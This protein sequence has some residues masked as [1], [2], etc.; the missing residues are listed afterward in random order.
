MTSGRRGRKLGDVR[1]QPG[2][3]P[4]APRRLTQRLIQVSLLR[5][6]WREVR[7]EV[8]VSR[9]P[10]S[11]ST[12]S[13]AH[14]QAWLRMLLAQHLLR[15]TCVIQQPLQGGPGSACHEGETSSVKCRVYTEER[16]WE[17]EGAA[18]PPALALWTGAGSGSMPTLGKRKV[19]SLVS[20]ILLHQL[21]TPSVQ[22]N[23]EGRGTQLSPSRSAAWSPTCSTASAEP[24][25]WKSLQHE[26]GRQL[27]AKGQ[28]SKRGEYHRLL[29]PRHRQGLE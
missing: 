16:R 7:S 12:L 3:E 26:Q 23:P 25:A 22:G 2:Q 20:S 13:L 28:E 4:R 18:A 6:R 1:R 17:P 11:G 24:P 15:G 21:S 9:D 10:F 5:L 19:G 29:Y 27:E 14:P 8:A